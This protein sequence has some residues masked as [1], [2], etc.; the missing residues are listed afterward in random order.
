MSDELELKLIQESPLRPEAEDE[1]K[2]SLLKRIYDEVRKAYNGRALNG[3]ELAPLPECVKDESPCPDDMLFTYNAIRVLMSRYMSRGENGLFA[4]TPSMVMARVALGM[5]ERVE[6]WSLYRLLVEGY[7][8]FNSPTLFNLYV[9]KAYGTLS[10][11]YVTPVYDSM[12][13]IMDA[14]VVQAMTFKWGGGQGFSFSELRPRWDTVRGTS[15]FSSGPMSFMQLY[16]TITELVKQGGKRRGANMG[17]MHVW[18][19]DIYTPGFDPYVALRNSLPPQLT[20]FID[21][22]KK[23]IEQVEAE[24]YEVDREFKAFVEN[25]SRQGWW[26]TEDAGFVQAKKPP[27]QDANLTNFNISV[28]IND[29]FMKALMEDSEWWMLNPRLSEKDGVYRIHYSISRAYGLGMLEEQLQRFPWLLENVYLNIYEDVADEVKLKGLRELEAVSKAKGWQMTPN[30]KNTLVWKVRARELWDEIV[31]NA[32]GGGDPG[33]IY[34]D[35]HNKWNPTPWLGALNATNP[36]SEQVLYPFENCNLGSFNLAKY[37][38]EGKFDVDRL[39]EDVEIITDAMDTAIDINNHPDERHYKVNLMTRKIGI[40][41]MGL[42]EALA[43]LGYPYDSDEAVAFSMIVSAA[44]EAFSW[45]RSWELGA[46]LGH[47]PAFECRKYDW[48]KFECVERGEPEELA[49]LLVPALTKAQKVMRIEDDW[50]KVRYHEGLRIPAEMRKFSGITEQ[51]VEE[52]GSLRLVPVEVAKRVLRENFGISEEHMERALSAS[53][54]EVLADPKLTLA[55]AVIAP[56]R[57]WELLK[58]HGRALGAR[59]PRNTVTTTVAP[60]G[61]ISIISG[62]SSGIEPFFALVFKRQVTVGTFLEIVREF[63]KDLL[64]LA[65]QHDVNRET[66][67]LVYD[68]IREH[69]GSIRMALAELESIEA[70]EGFKDGLRK[71]ARKYATAMDFDL[72]YHVAHQIAAQL[73]IDQAISKTVNLPK[74]ATVEDVHMVYLLAWLGGLKGFTVYRDESKGVQVIVFGGKGGKEERRLIKKRTGS[75]MALVKRQMNKDEAERDARLK[76]VFEVKEERRGE[77][78]V[79]KIT[80][81]STCKTCER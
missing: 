43:K 34:F 76:E 22:T 64:E 29:A 59:A 20:N 60:T 47:A 53:R 52:D 25:L 71:L 15:S 61:T 19:P 67:M 35:N 12:R 8:M 44:L 9:D 28:G 4:E 2:K 5:K 63:R 57:L 31:K 49:E 81:N 10:A 62:T 78:V 7:Y 54:E 26:S 32:W 1:A 56:G 75:R 66:I 6:P 38:K 40:G 68:I 16:D 73:F 55:L 70:P 46:K 18:H 41:F 23:L 50:I 33:V 51:R 30:E 74:D 58:E 27:L 65:N 48:R 80:E 11:C 14:G 72:W 45:K 42:A 36:C 13:E 77:E 69:K 79:V 17:I 3:G 37:V 39:A 24:G 21:A